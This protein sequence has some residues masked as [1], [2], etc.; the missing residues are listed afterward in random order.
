MAHEVD[1]QLQFLRREPD[2]PP[3]AKDDAAHGPDDHVPED[4]LG[5]LGVRRPPAP[6]QRLDARQQLGSLERL[7]R[8]VVSSRQSQSAAGSR[9]Q[10]A[11]RR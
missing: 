5:E 10:A 9:A 6:E 8:V 1:Q 11:V 3:A 4:V 2:R 7:G